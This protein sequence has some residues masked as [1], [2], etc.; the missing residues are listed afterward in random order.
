[1]GRVVRAAVALLG[2]LL[3]AAWWMTRPQT[4]SVAD[5]PDHEPDPVTGEDQASTDCAVCHY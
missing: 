1:M 2:A 4:F 3:V 5:L